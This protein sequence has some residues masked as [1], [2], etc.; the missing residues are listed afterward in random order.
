[1]WYFFVGMNTDSPKPSGAGDVG[2][3]QI[4][5]QFKFNLH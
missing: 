5:S 4:G 2:A 3:K 1:M